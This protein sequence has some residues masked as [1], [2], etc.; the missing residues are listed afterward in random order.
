MTIKSI[1]GNIEFW[2]YLIVTND[3]VKE[4]LLKAAGVSE[5]QLADDIELIEGMSKI[6][7]CRDDRE[8]VRKMWEKWL[9]NKKEVEALLAK[10]E[11]DTDDVV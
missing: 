11:E 9:N 4:S 10:T 7:F 5:T 6:D 8:K 2:F 1:L 3:E